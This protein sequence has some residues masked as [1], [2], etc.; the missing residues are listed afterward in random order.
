M[1]KLASLQRI[2]GVRP[3][4]GADRIEAVD[5]LGWTVVCTKGDFAVG[6]LAVYFEVDSWLDASDPRYATFEDRFTNWDGK[7]GMRLK[8]IKLRKQVS[9]GLL[10]KVENFPEIKS[11]DEGDDVTAL[12]GVVKWEPAEDFGAM[13]GA[14]GKK[15][16]GAKNFPSFIRKTDQERVQNY[17]NELRKHGDE[18][19][20]VTI[21]LDGSS[22]TLFH[23]GKSSP[24]YSFIIAD[25]EAR[26]LRNKSWLGRLAYKVQKFLGRVERPDAFTGVCSRNIQLAPDGDSHFSTFTRENKFL[27]K[28]KSHGYNIAVQ[29]ELIGPSIQQNYEKVNG[30]EFYVFDVFDIDAQEYVKP[31]RAR[32]IAADLGFSYVPVIAESLN[33]NRW[34]QQLANVGGRC[35]DRGVVEN[36]L[37]YAEGP[38]MNK[39]VKR[40]GV[41]FKS[42]ESDFSFKAISNSYL[43]KKEGKA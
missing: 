36:I 31:R 3:I 14:L 5:V 37:E 34:T 20:E 4:E 18:T 24:H 28:M 16:A 1:R 17:L 43:L 9:Q 41:V 13:G 38:G 19:F 21:K 2:V 10:L 11:R 27:E 35:S 22:M 23:V 6:D 40:E 12:I 33:L 26:E 32:A 30:L 25:Q 29:G 39:G 7:R 8:T 42:N 15:T